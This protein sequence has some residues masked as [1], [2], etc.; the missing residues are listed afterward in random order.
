LP[1]CR[2]F[3]KHRPTIIGGTHRSLNDEAF[4]V[5]DAQVDVENRVQRVDDRSELIISCRL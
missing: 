3:G 1:P 5:N 4:L 2:R